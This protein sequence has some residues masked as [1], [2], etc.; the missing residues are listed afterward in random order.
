MAALQGFP[1]FFCCQRHFYIYN[2]IHHYP[3]LYY[4]LLR[5]SA[6]ERAVCLAIRMQQRAVRSTVGCSFGPAQLVRHIAGGGAGQG[7]EQ[8]EG[9]LLLVSYPARSRGWLLSTDSDPDAADEEDEDGGEEEEEGEGEQGEG[10]E[11]T[12]PQVL[13][14]QC[15]L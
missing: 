15:A 14:P 10:E 4:H 6:L 3:L 13:H 2:K 1:N 5:F 8:G 9:R 11:G 7:A 12:D